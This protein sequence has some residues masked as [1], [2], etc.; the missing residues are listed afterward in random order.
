VE[1]LFHSQP[2][3]LVLE[4]LNKTR[5]EDKEHPSKAVGTFLLTVNCFLKVVN[6][7]TSLVRLITA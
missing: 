5:T 1:P 6:T 3:E 4:S 2:Q 7:N